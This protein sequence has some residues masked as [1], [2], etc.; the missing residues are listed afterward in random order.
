[1]TLKSQNNEEHANMF[2]FLISANVDTKFEELKLMKK[3]LCKTSIGDKNFLDSPHVVPFESPLFID[4]DF[5]K[6]NI[7]DSLIT[8]KAKFF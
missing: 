2:N 6:N 4:K 5:I 3:S 8:L 7:G 1:M